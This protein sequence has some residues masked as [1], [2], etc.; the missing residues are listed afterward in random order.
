MNNK[1]I[2]TLTLICLA[3]LLI[4]TLEWL[5]AEQAQKQLLRSIRFKEQQTVHDEMPQ[6]NVNQQPE[7][8][9]AD[10]VNRP[11]FI[12]GRK[13]VAEAD[14][15]QAINGNNDFDW[16]LSGIYTSQIGLKAL[17]TRK[18][19]QTPDT[20]PATTAKIVRYRKVIIGDDLDGWIIT[21][22]HPH[23]INLTRGGSK[24]ELPLRKPTVKKTQEQDSSIPLNSDRATLM[25]PPP[26]IPEP[27]SAPQ[28]EPQ[29]E[30]TDDAKNENH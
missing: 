15:S 1:L 11:L 18:E 16:L 21:E 19:V 22:I 12:Q 28:A 27:V 8:S 14:S 2:R 13:P 17:L 3:L 10:L 26:P 7:D 20:Q 9:Y 4:I 5:Y 23:K 25:R 6:F 29:P 30:L 24:K